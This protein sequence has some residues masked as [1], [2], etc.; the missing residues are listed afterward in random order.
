MMDNDTED[1]R[2]INQSHSEITD[3]PQDDPRTGGCHV[4]SPL[5][6][7]RSTH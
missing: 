6:H 1:D 5:I 7:P 3:D 4:G 2:E